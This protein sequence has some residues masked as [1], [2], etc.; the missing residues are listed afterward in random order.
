M[1]VGL[2]DANLVG[3]HDAKGFD[4]RF[5]RGKLD[6]F[7]VTRDQV[8]RVSTI[9]HDQ[10][11]KWNLVDEES[12]RSY[13]GSMY[14]TLNHTSHSRLLFVNGKKNGLSEIAAVSGSTSVKIEVAVVPHL[15]FTVA[16][17]FLQHL[18]ESGQMK[19]LTPWDPSDG[20]WLIKK[21]NW[22]YGLQAN[23]SFEL[24]DSE[25][26]RVDKVLGEPLGEAAFL[27][28]VVDKK[29]KNAD[30]NVFLVG[31]WKGGEAGG[32]YFANEKAAV[33][34]GN[35]TDPV[36]PDSDPFLVTLAH[37][38][39]HFLTFEQVSAVFHHNRPDVLLSS[40]IQSSRLDKQLLLQV[41]SPW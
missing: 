21:L 38:V 8:S 30:L 18:D 14:N 33:V 34:E 23:I 25:W 4:L 39:A 24:L 3:L 1:V 6:V 12:A 5:D 37:E 16:F 10:F 26:V 28:F 9:L 7:Q 2:G 17:K 22:I 15:S 27:N 31:R 20:Q 40:G 29:N 41:N 36:A 35:P 13:W 19:T 11:I 32:T